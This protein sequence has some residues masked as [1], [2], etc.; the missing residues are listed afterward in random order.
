M[1]RII[2]LLF[3]I[4]ALWLGVKIAQDSGYIF[5]AYQHWTIEM[6]LWLGIGFIFLIFLLLHIAFRLFHHV[7]CIPHYWRTWFQKWRNQRA[8][9]KT[10]Q[11]FLDVLHG[12]FKR[13]EKKLFRAA[14]NSP[15]GLI[16]Y[17]TAAKAAFS[18]KAYAR[19]DAYLEKA[20]GQMPE[21]SI[22]VG[23]TKAS[24]AIENQDFD[25]ALKIL[26][27]LSLE[28]PHNPNILMLLK[29]VYQ[30][31]H[32]WKNLIELLPKLRRSPLENRD[33]LK[34]LEHEAYVGLLENTSDHIQ[35]TWQTLPRPLH[36][37][38]VLIG[39]YAKKLHATQHTQEAEIVLKK[40]LKHTWDEN[41]IAMYR[42]MVT[43]RPTEQLRFLERF[44]KQH[45]NNATLCLT[46]GQFAMHAKLWGK[47]KHYLETSIKES[48]TPEAYR[49]LGKILE[50]L[51]D[52]D[53]AF[54]MYQKA[55]S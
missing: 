41:L 12:R 50:I 40:Y 30:Q 10:S 5:I 44:L 3:F 4:A 43:D 47:A 9:K 48:P 15:I 23:I 17:L 26:K 27:P 19:S 29:T 22:A 6:P 39:L 28:A 46:L 38:P 34:K 24:L 18:Q 55:A 13:G 53:G 1:R 16:N 25:L 42:E 49:M 31:Q 20:L 52:R 54:L 7:S 8:I 21:A 51:G 45:P 36:H 32:L 35:E 11:G 33:A 2:L 14:G 37:D